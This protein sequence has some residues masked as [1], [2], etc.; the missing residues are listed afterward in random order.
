MKILKFVVY[1]LKLFS[2]C[3]RKEKTSLKTEISPPPPKA[4]FSLTKLI[5]SHDLPR[6]TVTNQIAFDQRDL[7]STLEFERTMARLCQA[8]V[9]KLETSDTITF[10]YLILLVTSIS[11][12]FIYLGLRYK[13]GA[14]QVFYVICFRLSKNHIYLI[15]GLLTL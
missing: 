3:Q 1:L 10:T 7:Y 14:G 13:R 12:H 11:L 15:F 4:H 9:S 6:T 5:V 2:R 8:L